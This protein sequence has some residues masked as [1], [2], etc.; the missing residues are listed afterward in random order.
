[1]CKRI[2]YHGVSLLVIEW[3]PHSS[4][5]LMVWVMERT[6]LEQ[7]RRKITG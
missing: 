7:L 6:W 2:S 3:L 1:M 4:G 5:M